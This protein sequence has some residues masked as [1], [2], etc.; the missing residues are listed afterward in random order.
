MCN[1]NT[2]PAADGDAGFFD[3]HQVLH[4]ATNGRRT[5]CGLLTDYAIHTDEPETV[6]GCQECL[7]AACG[8]C[9]LPGRLRRSPT[10]LLLL[11]C[12]VQRW[13]GRGRWPATGAR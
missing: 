5:A 9:R 11:C 4:Y 6:A 10:G 2:Q 13:P 8:P 1:R 12:G 7:A 3:A